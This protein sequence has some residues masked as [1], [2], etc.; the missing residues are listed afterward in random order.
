MFK[1]IR[2]RTLII[3]AL[4]LLTA[5]LVAVGGMGI[6]N[7][8]HSVGL[9]RDVS[10]QDKASDATVARIKHGMETN[11]TQVLLALQHNPGFEHAAMHDHPVANHLNAIAENSRRIQALW[12][13][14]LGGIR[15]TEE[16][17]LADAW[18]AASGGLGIAGIDE[19]VAAIQAEKWEQAV[20][21]LLKTI[22]PAYNRGQVASQSLS[23][24]LAQRADANSAMVAANLAHT[25]QAMLAVL[26]IGAL[27]AVGIGLFLLRAIAQPLNDA[28][29]IANGV[30]KGDLTREIEV[31]STNEI[32]QLLGALHDMAASLSAIVAEV[33]TGTDTVASASMQIVAG[34]LDLSSRTEQQAA[35]IQETAS[36]ME[37]ITSTVKLNAEHARDA[38]ELARSASE[39][40][41]KGGDVVGQVVDTMNSI[42]ASA[43]KI[44]D[45][46]GVIDGIAFQTNILA[47]NAA[48]EAARAGEQGRGFAVVAS[49]VRTLAQRSAAAAKEI[50]A[51]IGDSVEK[52]ESG[53]RLVDQAGSTMREIV[54]SIGKV[55]YI[56]GEISTASN[57][58]TA[59]IEQINRAITQM[60][61][62]T[63]RNA[64]LVEESA[65]AAQSLRD[66]A[67]K[68]TAAVAVF[69]LRQH[70]V[71][72]PPTA[73]P[74]TGG[75]AV[76]PLP[77][78]P[79]VAVKPVAAA[80]RMKRLANGRPVS[81]TEWEE[82]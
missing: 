62:A 55:T 12:S 8:A 63:Q 29:D 58:Q 22:N 75:A 11:R 52:V 41:A 42:N 57:E 6:Y 20:T 56:M 77:E 27:F 3:V 80:P 19:A 51:L 72:A 73:A 15:S 46:I 16:K 78:R 28:I 50:K 7:G 65:S 14:Y 26:V 43:R 71:E 66:Q 24:F 44:V 68:L 13:D 49:E 38:N 54:S 39:V 67:G 5:L 18:Y 59:G 31:T 33:H 82:F 21:I 37:E 74:A 45:I 2:I 1:N 60:D 81:G 4:G 25:G 64:A 23:D 17:A 36:S 53:S 79:D 32:G 48:V 47:L 76:I 9:M 35:S 61:Q 30:A 10:V 69:K 34:N 40:A 70:G